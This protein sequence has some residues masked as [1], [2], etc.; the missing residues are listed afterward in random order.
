[1]SKTISQEKEHATTH[2]HANLQVAKKHTQDLALNM[3]T[4]LTETEESFTSHGLCT[5]EFEYSVVGKMFRRKQKQDITKKSHFARQFYKK[6]AF[7]ILDP[8]CNFPKPLSNTFCRDTVAPEKVN[9]SIFF[10]KNIGSVYGL[11][12]FF[13]SSKKESKGNNN[14]NNNNN[15]IIIIIII[16]IKTD[17]SKKNWGTGNRKMTLDTTLYYT[18]FFFVRNQHCAI[19]LEQLIVSSIKIIYMGQYNIYLLIAI[20]LGLCG[21]CVRVINNKRR[22]HIMV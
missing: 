22:L 20:M 9:H 14:N 5:T 10:K 13:H 11:L 6:N 4:Q 21:D 7:I 2:I 17:P 15:I 18:Q 1:M 3:R 12:A 8:R 19:E 16:I